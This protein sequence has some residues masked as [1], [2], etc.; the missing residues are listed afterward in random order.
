[1]LRTG[2][3][4]LISQLKAPLSPAKKAA[5]RPVPPPHDKH[6]LAL[7]GWPPSDA[8]VPFLD[9]LSDSQLEELNHILDYNCFTVDGHGRRFG[10]PAGAKK[11]RSP[12]EIPDRRI[13]LL[14]EA[15]KLANKKVLEVGCFEGVH[16]IALCQRAASVTA[17]DSRVENVVKTIVR[18]A[19]YDQRPRVVV[20]DLEKLVSPVPQWM[21]ADVGFHV[22]VL[23]HLTDPVRHL[24]L[25]SECLS[26][27]LL[28]DTHVARDEQ[29]NAQYE[30]E[31]RAWKYYR[32]K[33]EGYRAVFAGMADHAKWLSEEDLHD[34][35]R[36]NGFTQITSIEQ[37]NEKNGKRVL[38][39]ARRQPN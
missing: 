35:L 39:L 25:L 37:R 14:A 10:L 5:K 16:T 34:V 13:V 38:L 3:R 31:G 28:L 8:P 18:T 15:V 1:M 20:Y 2:I 32:L 9:M 36:S 21:R 11:R 30:S 27:A 12:Q 7:K 19:F 6:A 4:T 24:K 29:L 17:L 33:E 26:E 23:Y 22:G